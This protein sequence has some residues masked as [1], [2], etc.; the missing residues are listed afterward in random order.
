MEDVQLVLLAQTGDREAFQQLLRRVYPALLRYVTGLVGNTAADDVVQDTAIQIHRNLRW[1]R[2]P[3][4]F[5][6]WAYRIASRFAIAHLK[7]TKRWESLDDHVE[8]IGE[9]AV[10]A[11]FEAK[12]LWSDQVQVLAEQLS[13][14]SRAV[15]LLH[16][17][18]GQTF[19]E[20]SAVLEIP[21]GTVKSRLFYAVKKLRTWFAKEEQYE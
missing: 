19:E 12:F 20:I 4:Y 10:T 5:R 13:P 8:S 3:S 18:H 6:S 7:R 11:D 21:I 15:F 17:Q 9:N 16:Y 2:E 1:L 14:A